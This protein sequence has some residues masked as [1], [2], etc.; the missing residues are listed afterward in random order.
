MSETT[1]TCDRCGKT[2][3]H[4]SDITTGYG[5][6]DGDKKHCFEC[7]GETDREY[8]VANGKMTL[9]LDT[10]ARTVGNWPGTLKFNVGTINKG[11]H[12]IARVRYDFWFPGPDGKTWHGV[13][14]G[15]WTQIAHCKRTKG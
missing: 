5:V 14:Y 10:K 1:F 13:Q 8:M 3:T 15:D 11:Y 2:K 12:N 9:Y 4:K 7:C 6:V